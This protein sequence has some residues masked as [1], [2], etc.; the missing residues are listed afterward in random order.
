M[1]FYNLNNVIP[2]PWILL[3]IRWNGPAERN[4]PIS[5]QFYFYSV[6]ELKQGN[7]FCFPCV[8]VLCIDDLHV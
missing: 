1:L 7:K 2:Y 5:D 6:L 8:F 3:S 4:L